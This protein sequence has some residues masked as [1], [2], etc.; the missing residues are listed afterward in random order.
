MMFDEILKKFEDQ[1]IVL[2][3]KIRLDEI[4]EATDVLEEKNT[5]VSDKIR[6]LKYEDNIIAQEIT[7]RDELA[8]R[9]MSS[10]EEAEEFVANRLDVYEKMWDGCGCKVNYYE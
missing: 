1:K 2:L 9:L 4:L 7:S 3:P 5:L 6:I 10:L 8:L